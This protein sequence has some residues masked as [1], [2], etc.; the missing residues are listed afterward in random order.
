MPIYV[1]CNG[2]TGIIA[3]GPTLY[4]LFSLKTLFFVLFVSSACL[5]GSICSYW[6]G[7]LGGRV[8]VKW[9]AGD[10]TEYNM[11]C[12][13]LN[14]K[15][16]KWIYAL[17][18]I[19]PIFPDDIICLVVGAMKIQFKFFV[20]INIIGNI[21]GISCF[22]IFMRLPVI[23]KFLMGSLSGNFP[24]ALIIYLILLVLTIIITIIWKKK[25]MLHSP[26]YTQGNR[27]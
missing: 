10:E 3:N 12:K 18:V 15:R 25:I 11:W 20:T 23:S 1:F 27:R 16:G 5:M 9:I 8:A 21:L 4:D 6:M 14:G 19:L 2:C 22:C 26:V 7:R 17:T 13:K 24:W